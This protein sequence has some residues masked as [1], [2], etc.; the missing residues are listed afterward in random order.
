MWNWQLMS[1][2]RTLAKCTVYCTPDPLPAPAHTLN[3][4]DAD[5]ISSTTTRPSSPPD[6]DVTLPALLAQLLSPQAH[7]A[8]YNCA[9]TI[10]RPCNA[11]LCTAMLV[12]SLA[13]RINTGTYNAQPRSSLWNA[14]YSAVT[15]WHSS[16]SKAPSQTLL[17]HGVP[18]SPSN[19]HPAA[20]T[21]TAATCIPFAHTFS[22]PT[23]IPTNDTLS[24][25][26][27]GSNDDS[28]CVA[29]G[30]EHTDPHTQSSRTMLTDVRASRP[31]PDP[32]TDTSDTTWVSRTN[33][34]KKSPQPPSPGN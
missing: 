33:K 20:I 13:A 3:V 24:I 15:S 18:D 9:L 12:A 1:A 6:T 22:R 30:E 28:S 17:L 31:S 23:A 5:I 11:P 21:S 25:S 27:T 32:C 7:P 14:Q 29:P 26:A 34:G 19:S 16:E 4:R 8:S 10:P 2:T